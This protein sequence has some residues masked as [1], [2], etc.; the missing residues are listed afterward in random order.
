MRTYLL[1]MTFVTVPLMSLAQDIS[2][3]PKPIIFELAFSNNQKTLDSLGFINQFSHVRAGSL[4]IKSGRLI[5]SDPINLNITKP[6]NFEFPKGSFKVEFAYINDSIPDTYISYVR[7][8]LSN[9]P[10]H[11]WDVIKDFGKDTSVRLL[12]NY[13]AYSESGVVLD[14]NSV[15][16]IGQLMHSQ[17]TSL[18]IDGLNNVEHPSWLATKINEYTVFGFR[19]FDRNGSR[20]YIGRDIKDKPCRLL[21]ETGMFQLHPS[22]Y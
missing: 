20:I 5:V 21:I 9:Q 13:T 10:V 1:L 3:I 18:F 14:L 8:M 2:S 15:K 22:Q 17:W 12:R 11:R 7:V 6:L 4:V 19:G 16:S